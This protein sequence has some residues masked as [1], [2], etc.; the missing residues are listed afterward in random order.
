MEPSAL[1]LGPNPGADHD[2]IL[3]D[4][5]LNTA[6]RLRQKTIK[7]IGLN[8]MTANPFPLGLAL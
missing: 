4:R 8:P 5:K 3:S 1:A 6:P 7:I 2:T